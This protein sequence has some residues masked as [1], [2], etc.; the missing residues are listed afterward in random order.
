[1]AWTTYTAVNFRNLVAD[2]S[3]NAG[4][5]CLA[6]DPLNPLSIPSYAPGTHSNSPLTVNGNT[7]NI[8]WTTGGG[9]DGAR[10]RTVNTPSSSDHRLAGKHGGVVSAGSIL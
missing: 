10:T 8:G 6:S 3:E 4:E 7:F 1:M 2:T 9:Q 5:V